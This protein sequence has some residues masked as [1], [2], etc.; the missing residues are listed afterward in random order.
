MRQYSTYVLYKRFYCLY[1]SNKVSLLRLKAHIITHS[2]NIL[3]NMRE[4]CNYRWNFMRLYVSVSWRKRFFTR[5]NRFVWTIPFPLCGDFNGFITLET[6]ALVTYS[7]G[8]LVNGNEYK[9][10]FWIFLIFFIKHKNIYK[11]I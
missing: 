2:C 5:N 6:L 11:A 7:R 10:T 8:C 9:I 3:S 1:K 4:F